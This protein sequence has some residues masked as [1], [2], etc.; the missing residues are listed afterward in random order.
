MPITF[1][2]NY[3]SLIAAN[4]LN[5]ISANQTKTI[6]QL[7]SGFRINSSADDAAGLAVSNSYN[8][9]IAELTQ[10]VLN[11]NQ[12]VSQL[13]IVDG[14]LSNITTILNRLKT[15][16]AESASATFAGDRNNINTE[17]QSLLTEV[18]QQASNIGLD[19]G[20]KLNILNQVYIGG[21][22][23][24]A[25]SQIAVD[26]SGA[27]NQVDAFGLGISTTSVVGGGT[28]LTGGTP[29]TLRLDT[30]GVLYVAGGAQ[31]FNFQTIVNNAAISVAA[32]VTGTTAG[33]TA[34]QV[35]GQLNGTLKAY[36]ITAQV[37]SDGQINFGGATAFQVVTAG[38][39]GGGTAIATTA[40]SAINKGNYNLS[41]AVYVPPA[42]ST[43]ETLS[44]Q[45]GVDYQTVTIAVAATLADAITAVNAALNTGGKSLG[46]FA[47]KNAAGTGISFQ[48]ASSFTVST[49]KAAQVFGA[50]AITGSQTVTAPGVTAN[51][52]SNA[53]SAITSINDALAKLGQIQSRI[54]AGENKL[55]YAITLANS[56]IVNYSAALSGIRD[57]DVAAAAAALT[58]GQVLQQASVAALA[59]ANSAPQSLLKLFQ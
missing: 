58:K 2:T 40:S 14:G 42:A 50:L 29:N 22:S 4:N 17:F 27:S 8:S 21:G 10:G 56:Q 39:S 20:G 3:A 26:L 59:Q 23:T 33:L 44:F 49:D 51:I 43:A 24:T 28:E 45:N 48:S 6:Q 19:N 5:V 41:A 31:T 13:Q 54:G 35:V 9:S 36:G 37:G 47:T 18:T 1:Q 57:T 32:T 15:L 34:D 30:P 12:G 11:G 46:I 52:T 25:N 38:A 55:A 7:T 16:A 53:L